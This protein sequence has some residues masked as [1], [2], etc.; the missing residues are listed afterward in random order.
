MP[1]HPGD[2]HWQTV[3]ETQDAAEFHAHLRRLRAR[4]ERVDESKLR[5][6]TLCG[7]LTYPTTYRLSR[8]VPGP[9]REPG[10]A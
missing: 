1:A 8:L 10:Q 4:P 3:Y 5:I 7:R 2:G 9:A 6:D